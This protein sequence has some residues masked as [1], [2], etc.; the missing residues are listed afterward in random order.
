MFSMDT[1][2]I[3]KKSAGVS[4]VEEEKGHERAEAHSKGSS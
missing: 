3:Q 1:L 2:D 4:E